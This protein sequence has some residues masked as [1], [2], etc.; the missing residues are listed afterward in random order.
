MRFNSRLIRA[1]T[2]L[3]SCVLAVTVMGASAAAD[4]HHAVRRDPPHPPT[5]GVIQYHHMRFPNFACLRL[6]YHANGVVVATEPQALVLHLQSGGYVALNVAPNA[7]IRNDQGQMEP[8]SSIAAGDTV[9]APYVVTFNGDLTRSIEFLAPN[10]T[11]PPLAPPYRLRGLVT[12]DANGVLQITTMAGQQVTVDLTSATKLTSRTGSGS[13]A[14]GDFVLAEVQQNGSAIDALSV[15]FD[16]QPF[17]LTRAVY[18]GT[19]A[20]LSGSGGTIQ[21][22]GQTYPFVLDNGAVVVSPSGAS[23]TL[24]TGAS[25]H[26]HAAMFRGTLYASYVSETATP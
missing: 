13:L 4:G 21:A 22:N 7:I 16:T 8:L 5:C 9:V 11:P 17:W 12:S 26:M 25:V 18:V 23:T 15:I 20:S 14:S 2:A 1:L 19:I 24:T 6:R 3:G 10:T